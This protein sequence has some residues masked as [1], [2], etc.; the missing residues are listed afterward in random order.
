MIKETKM[1]LNNHPKSSKTYRLFPRQDKKKLNKMQLLHY[2][3]DKLSR[4][5]KK[6]F[7]P[8]LSCY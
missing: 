2:K 6:Q 7:F 8:Y 1:S 4:M 5:K 3:K